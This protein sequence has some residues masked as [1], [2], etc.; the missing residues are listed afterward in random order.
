[1][2]TFI[3]CIILKIFFSHINIVFCSNSA[4][5][6]QLGPFGPLQYF[7]S[8]QSISVHSIHFGLIEP[9]INSFL[10]IAFSILSS[11]FILFFFLNIWVKKYEILFNLGK[12]LQFLLKIQTEQ[13]L[14]I[15]DVEPKIYIYIYDKYPKDYLEIQV[16]IIQTLYTYI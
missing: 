2:K 14:E 7:N 9:Y 13:T 4:H 16:S 8:I 11:K 15:R 10:Q 1:M 5:S 6:V 12:T 3:R